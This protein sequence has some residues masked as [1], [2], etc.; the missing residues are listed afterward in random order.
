MVYVALQHRTRKSVESGTFHVGKIGLRGKNTE[1]FRIVNFIISIAG[2]N[3][4]SNFRLRLFFYLL[5]AIT[6]SSTRNKM[7]IIK[8]NNVQNCPVINI[9]KRDW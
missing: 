4:K 5:V 1:V 7:S 6:S 8:Q 9:S 3:G 2:A